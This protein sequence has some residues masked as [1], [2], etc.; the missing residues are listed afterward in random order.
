MYLAEPLTLKLTQQ[1]TLQTMSSTK[2]SSML[3]S[4]LNPKP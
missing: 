2:P 4:T 1:L 3:P